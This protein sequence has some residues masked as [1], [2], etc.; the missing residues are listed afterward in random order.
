MKLPMLLA[1]RNL[2]A[3]GRVGR[4]LKVLL[5]ILAVD[6][7][8]KLLLLGV[9]ALLLTD[10]LLES[11]VNLLSGELLLEND[12]AVPVALPVPSDLVMIV[13]LLPGL[14][15][16]ALVLPA[17]GIPL[18]MTATPRLGIRKSARCIW[19]TSRLHENLVA[20]PNTLG[21]H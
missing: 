10:V 9:L 4:L 14:A 17:P 20:P 8:E 18:L 21:L 6:D 7:S 13:I 15:L 3:C 11:L 5:I 12:L 19:L 16:I 1:R 2:I